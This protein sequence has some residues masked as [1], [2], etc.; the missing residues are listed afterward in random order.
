[1]KVILESVGNPDFGQ[2][3][4]KG[5]SPKQTV[6]VKSFEEA[7]DAC[8]DYIKKH[9]LGG[10]NWSGGQVTEGGKQVAYISYNGRIWLD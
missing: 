1:M 3:P 10:G 4:N 8:Q 2:N 6:D 5:V 9:D 7:S